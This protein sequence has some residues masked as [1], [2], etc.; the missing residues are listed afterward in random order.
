[1]RFGIGVVEGFYGAPWSPAARSA[2]FRF[3][4]DAGYSSYLYAPKA[5]R[6]L[7]ADWRAEPDG[8]W[9][10]ALDDMIGE[11]RAERLYLGVGLSPM[12]ADQDMAAARKQLV[13]RAQALAERGVDMLA[14]LFDDMPA[15]SDAAARQQVELTRAVA[16]ASGIPRL[17]FCP[18]WYSDDPRLETV[19]GPCP[20]RYLET[21]GEMLDAEIGVFWTG[22]QVCTAQWTGEH[23]ENI[24]ARLG[25]PP[26]LW[27]NYPV[28]DGPRMCRQL[29]L[30]AF[31]GRGVAVSENCDGVFVNPMNQC[32]LSWAPLLTLPWNL[33]QPGYDADA[34]TVAAFRRT[35]PVTLAKR[36][37]RD[38]RRFAA[39]G[40]D[41]M[42]EDERNDL[43]FDYAHIDHPA[44]REVVD[45]L[46]GH[47]L[48][49]E[50]VLQP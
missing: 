9:Y 2:T 17:L 34:A 46:R 22:P 43:A 37:E 1:M 3:L 4:A 19:S 29:H 15:A 7:R 49:G 40:Y 39:P 5:D 8:E 28:N 42:D 6:V 26:V 36:L 41:G 12:G 25:R 27:D 14:L 21:I 38:W 20:A 24:T 18:T 47:T 16:D 33:W 13:A 23:L 50:E 44:A 35:L 32:A 31:E 30:R 10:A 48:V 11:C 45:W